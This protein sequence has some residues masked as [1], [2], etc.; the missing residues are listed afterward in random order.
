MNSQKIKQVTA[1][2]WQLVLVAWCAWLMSVDP[3]CGD[4]GPKPDGL[5]FT[6]T[7]EG[8]PLDGEFTAAVLVLKAEDDAPSAQPPIRIQVSLPGLEHGIPAEEPSSVWTYA[9]YM[10]GG[11]GT[12]GQV[13]FGHLL[14]HSDRIRLAV[15]VDSE[16]RLYVSDEGRTH[17]LLTHFNVT[18]SGSDKATLVRVETGRRLADA[19]LALEEH[20]LW[21]AL[22]ITLAAES[23][24]IVLAMA[25]QGMR[26]RMLRMFT[27]CLVVNC[28]SLPS[29]WLF[30][31]LGFYCGALWNGMVFLGILEAG[32]VLFEGAAYALFGKQGWWG[33]ILSLIANVASFSAGVVSGLL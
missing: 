18:L 5:H 15:Y 2:K 21:I 22:G 13:D 16:R 19:L 17:P 7:R 26:I 11:H 9:R 33:V 24:V 31:I 30:A 29:L 25:L 14:N 28:L 20:G 3:A 32:V 1:V 4:A 12:D 27:I 6:V 23:L 8:R 10:W